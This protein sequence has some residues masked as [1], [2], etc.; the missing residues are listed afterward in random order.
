MA[1]FG[2]EMLESIVSFSALFVL[3]KLLSRWVGGGWLEEMGIRP[4]Q[5]S[6]EVKAEIGNTAT[7]VAYLKLLGKADG[8]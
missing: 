5:L 4:S 1:Q 7:T 8:G 2:I 3:F 6:T